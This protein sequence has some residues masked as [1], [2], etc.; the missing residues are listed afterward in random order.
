MSLFSSECA[1][2]CLSAHLYPGKG[3][4]RVTP[5]TLVGFDS[6]LILRGR[7]TLAAEVWFDA[8]NLC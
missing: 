5:L 4:L 3:M 6:I 2:A 1:R 8:P 7:M